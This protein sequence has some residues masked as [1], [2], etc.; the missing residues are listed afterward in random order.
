[1]ATTDLERQSTSKV[2]VA[3]VPSRDWGW[4]G[5]APTAARISGVLFAILLLLMTIGNHQGK[6]EDIFLVGFAVVILG[7]ILVQWLT[8]R[9]KKWKY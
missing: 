3:D 8:T 1:M 5:N 7:S 4:S 2:D 6:T 9:R